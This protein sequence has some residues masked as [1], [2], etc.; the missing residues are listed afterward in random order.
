MFRQSHCAY[1]RFRT[2]FP[3]PSKTKY[4]LDKAFEALHKICITK[5]FGERPEKTWHHSASLSSRC[6]PTRISNISR[7]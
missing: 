7:L 1:A 6:V 3:L 2:E 5:A 4:G